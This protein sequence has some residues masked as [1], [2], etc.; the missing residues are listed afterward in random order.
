MLQDLALRST[1]VHPEGCS[2]SFPGSLAICHARRYNLLSYSSF[3]VVVQISNPVPGD[4]QGFPLDE[5]RFLHQEN[6]NCNINSVEG[7]SEPRHTKIQQ[8]SATQAELF[9][10]IEQPSRKQFAALSSL[11]AELDFQDACPYCTEYHA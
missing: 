7:S 6:H 10:N 9:A 11:F 2:L 5:R 3:E 8:L 4:A 1:S